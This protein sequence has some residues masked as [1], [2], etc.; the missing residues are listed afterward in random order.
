LAAN[1]ACVSFIR[2][3][4]RVCIPLIAL[5]FTSPAVAEQGKLRERHA[6]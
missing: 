2:L 1:G 4:V 3:G 5:V 6:A